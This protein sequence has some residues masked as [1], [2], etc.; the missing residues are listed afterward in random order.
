MVS[1][2][3]TVYFYHDIQANNHHFVA[4]VPNIEIKWRVTKYIFLRISLWPTQCIP[5]ISHVPAV[6]L[7]DAGGRWRDRAP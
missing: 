2:V 1:F 4:Q 3:I 5:L 7:L 6:F